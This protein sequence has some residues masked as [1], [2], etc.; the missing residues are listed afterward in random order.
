MDV[1]YHRVTLTHRDF[2]KARVILN[3][4]YYCYFWIGNGRWRWGLRLM[5]SLA[6]SFS[7]SLQNV[8]WLVGKCGI[9]SRDEI[10]QRWV[11]VS[12][13]PIILL[14]LLSVVFRKT[15]TKNHNLFDMKHGLLNWSPIITR[16]FSPLLSWLRIEK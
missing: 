8:V 13:Y 1:W 5:L 11:F 12:H 15:N 6:L 7:M 4:H 14:L 16:C 9:I 2:D 10:K 3:I